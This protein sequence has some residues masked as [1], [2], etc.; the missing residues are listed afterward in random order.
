M[1]I[2]GQMKK[3]VKIIAGVTLAIVLVAVVVVIA[4]PQVAATRY[5]YFDANSG[6]KK[7]ECISFG[8]VYQQS[9]EDTEYSKLLKNLGYKETPAEWK[10]ASRESIGLRNLFPPGFVDYQE[11]TIEAQSRMF[12]MTVEMKKLDEAKARELVERFRALI[13]KG[14]SSEVRQYVSL[15]SQEK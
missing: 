5:G 14:D 11:G 4:F 15:L 12:A 1:Q 10:L 3:R 13:Q 7:V 6:R 9:V 2:G 8:R